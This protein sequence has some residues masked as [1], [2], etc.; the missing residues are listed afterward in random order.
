MVSCYGAGMADD[1]EHPPGATAPVTGHYR[2]LNVFGSPT[3]LSAHILSGDALP[4]APRGHTWRLEQ[5]TG[6]D[7]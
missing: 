6:E 1:T 5:E 4:Y 7:E 2:L 3:G